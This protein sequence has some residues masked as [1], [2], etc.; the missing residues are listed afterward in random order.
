MSEISDLDRF[1]AKANQVADD[2]LE[3]T[4]RMVAMMEDTQNTGVKTLDMLDAQGE[5]LNRTENNLDN[6]NA[7]MKEADKALTGME[8]WCGLFVCPWNKTLA[9]ST[10]DS[11]WSTKIENNN[12]N[13]VHKQPEGVND[14][15]DGT[16]RGPYIQRIMDDAR[17]DEMEA[18]LK[19]V[20][21]LIGN[22]KNMATTMNTEISRQNQQLDTIH[23]KT[24]NADIE[25]GHANKRTEKLL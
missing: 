7:T 16:S 18:N 14:S 19:G 21:N 25:I 3:S 8:K 5:Q 9:P 20:D 11:V 23:G 1:K 22:L 15:S 10:D 13:P 24:I 17:E 6:I 2:S 4:R 12:S